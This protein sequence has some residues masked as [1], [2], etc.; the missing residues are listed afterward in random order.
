M[1]GVT[2][3]ADERPCMS[4]KTSIYKPGYYSRVGIGCKLD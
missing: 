4:G 2:S 1:L 3:E